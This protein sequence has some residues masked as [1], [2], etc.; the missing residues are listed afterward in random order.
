MT[1]TSRGQTKAKGFARLDAGLVFFY[2]NFN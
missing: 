2:L 1:V